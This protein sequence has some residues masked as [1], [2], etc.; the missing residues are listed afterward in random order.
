VEAFPE[1]SFDAAYSRFGVMFFE[2]P[3]AAFVN[4]RKALKPGGR[5]TFVCWRSYSENDWMRLP[6]EAAQSLLPPI[7][8]SDPTAPGPFAF[9]DAT[10]VRAILEGAGFSGLAISPF[11]ARIGGGDLDQ[12]LELTFRVGPLGMALRQNP[13]LAPKVSAAVRTLLEGHLT[14]DSVKM[15]AAVWIVSAVA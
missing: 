9:A 10:G 15:P 1:A 4:I 5:L 8:P 11:D 6:M 3:T 13:E 14:E 7:P 12:T 2:N